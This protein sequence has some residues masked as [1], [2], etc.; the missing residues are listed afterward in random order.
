[1]WYV[2]IIIK[3]VVNEKKKNYMVA[4]YKDD[5]LRGF[6]EELLMIKELFIDTMF[7]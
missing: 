5:I 6:S 7:I 4:Y 2:D 3:K 1:M